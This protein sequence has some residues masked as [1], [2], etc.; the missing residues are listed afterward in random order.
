M[1]TDRARLRVREKDLTTPIAFPYLTVVRIDSS[2][3]SFD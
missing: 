2:R 3:F 1:K